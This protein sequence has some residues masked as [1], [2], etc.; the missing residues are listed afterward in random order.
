MKGPAGLKSGLIALLL[1]S[2]GGIGRAAT[3]YVSPT[4]SDAGPGTEAAPWRTIRKAADTVTPGDTAFIRTGTY[5]EQVV[6]LNSGTDGA[7][8]TYAAYPGETA[9]VDGAGVDVPEWAGLFDITLKAYIRVSGLRVVN[10]FSNPHNPG[11]L[12]DTSQH[13]IIEFC[14][15]EKT[16]DS[17]IGVWNSQDVVVHGNA[18]Y[19]VCR[20]GWNECISVGESNAVEVRGNQVSYSNKEGICIKDGSFDVRVY[21]NE[22]FGTGAVGFYVDA[23]DQWTHDIEV[24]GNVSHDGA[25]NGFALA[26]E[27]GG[28]LEHINVYNNIAYANGWTGLQVTACCIATH[29]MSNIHITNNTFYDNGRGE[30]GGGIYLEN[31][32]AHGVVIRNNLLSEN[33]TFQLAVGPGTDFAADHNLIDV[34]RWSE[35]EITGE[36]P[37]E[38]DPQFADSASADFHI[39]GTSPAVD[40]GSAENAP[41]MDFDG[42]P[43]PQGLGFDIG[44]FEYRSHLHTRPVTRP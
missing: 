1:L 19:S 44:A 2:A 10:S 38:G 8:I 39:P 32:Q 15:I 30:W 18:V 23:Q 14:Y 17:G 3:Y 34:F 31:P 27:V 12:A 29:P 26:S 11:I 20:A 33:L 43:R 28:L 42:T 36:A 35:G 37:V 25:E 4:G 7:W 41:G 9:T 13:V 6:P 22:V 24:F 16:N 21:G 40:R 5:H